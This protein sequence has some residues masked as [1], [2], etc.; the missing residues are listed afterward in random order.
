MSGFELVIETELSTRSFPYIIEFLERL[1]D[2]SIKDENKLN[3]EI[4]P[5]VRAFAERNWNDLDLAHTSVLLWLERKLSTDTPILSSL[6]KKESDKKPGNKALKGLK[7]GI[8]TLTEKAGLR[9]AEILKSQFEGIEVILNHDKV[10]TDKLT[11]LAKTAD[12]FIFCNKSAAHQ[13]YY[14]VK[15][16]TKDIIY[17]E[18]K[19]TSSIV[20]AFL[21]ATTVQN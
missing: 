2:Y 11:N 8:S 20:R 9:A 14:A 10:A 5:K 7:V 19:G 15:G 6:D 4:W 3:Y 18:G 1:H 21:R 13:A 12:Y 16:I 17:V